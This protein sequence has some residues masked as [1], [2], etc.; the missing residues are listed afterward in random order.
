MLSSGSVCSTHHSQTDLLRS[1]AWLPAN[2][3]TPWAWVR[4]SHERDLEIQG[5]YT[6]CMLPWNCSSKNTALGSLSFSTVVFFKCSLLTSMCKNYESYKIF[7]VFWLHK[8]KKNEWSKEVSYVRAEFLGGL[9]DTSKEKQQVEKEHCSCPWNG[10]TPS[11][12]VTAS[13]TVNKN[14]QV[15]SHSEVAS[16]I[17][18]NSKM[19]WESS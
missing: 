3:V 8:K 13:A 19:R 15:C 2:S 11:S 4:L 14:T 1:T 10:L 7:A 9:V 17:W 5:F 6:L 16:Y 18:H 12:K